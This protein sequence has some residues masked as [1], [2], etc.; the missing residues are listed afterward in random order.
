MLKAQHVRL[1]S[2]G[3]L[4]P[5]KKYT[6]QPQPF[7]SSPSRSSRASLPTSVAV[8]VVKEHL[9][10][11]IRSLIFVHLCSRHLLRCRRNARCPTKRICLFSSLSCLFL[12]LSL[13]LKLFCNARRPITPRA[14][15]M[16]RPDRRYDGYGH[17]RHPVHVK[18]DLS[19]NLYAL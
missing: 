4:V 17:V 1:K 6:I 18:K 5:Y 11:I 19:L 14:S 2:R 15:D 3:I 8:I 10:S 13:S 7:F 12:L 16:R 9:L